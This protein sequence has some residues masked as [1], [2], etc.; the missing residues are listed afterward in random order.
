M[1]TKNWNY[2]KARQVWDIVSKDLNLKKEY[3]VQNVILH[4]D[5]IQMQETFI[6]VTYNEINIP[7]VSKRQTK[8]FYLTP[9]EIDKM[10]SKLDDMMELPDNVRVLH[11]HLNA[12]EIVSFNVSYTPVLK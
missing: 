6:D 8:R 9:E 12:N 10:F 3:I 7:K 1:N 2:V 5:A 4:I 11:T